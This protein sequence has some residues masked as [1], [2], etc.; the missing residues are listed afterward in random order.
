VHQRLVFHQHLDAARTLNELVQLGWFVRVGHC[1]REGAAAA[2][3]NGQPEKILL[4]MRQQIKDAPCSRFRNFQCLLLHT[5]S[6]S[7]DL[8]QASNDI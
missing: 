4:T 3:H 2:R 8:K 7:E 1:V 5:L 6:R